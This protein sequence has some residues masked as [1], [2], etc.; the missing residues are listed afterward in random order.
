MKTTTILGAL[1]LSLSAGHV[2]AD[3]AKDLF[4]D[5]WKKYEENELGEA[6]NKLRALIKLVEDLTAKRFEAILPE[7]VADWSGG[8]VHRA[9]TEMFG[10]GVS[11][12]RRYE[13]GAKSITVKLVK[14]SPLGDKLMEVLDNDDLV[15]WSGAKVHTIYGEKAIMEGE[16]KL[17]MVVAGEIYVELTGDNDTGKSDLVSFA[18]KIDLKTLKKMK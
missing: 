11:M 5:A 3:D 1:L 12:E 14:D 9:S 2:A 10:G 4:R 6:T 7:R 18:R 17:M 13:K 15:A 8:N 16:R